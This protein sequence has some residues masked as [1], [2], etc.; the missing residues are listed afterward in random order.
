MTLIAASGKATRYAL[1]D[2]ANNLIAAD[3]LPGDNCLATQLTVVSNTDENA[4]VQSL[5]SKVAAFPPLPATG[6]LEAGSIYSYG[7]QALVVR[8]S[9]FRTT[10]APADT[11]NLFIVYRA[12]AAKVLDWIAGEK[13][14]V[15]VH[16]LYGGQEYKCLQ[17]HVTQADWTPDR[18]P[19]LWAL[20]VEA[21]SGNEWAVGVTYKA[22]DIVTYKGVTY[23]CTIGHTSISVW[24][25]DVAVSLWTKV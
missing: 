2:A 19:N 20:Y 1:F 22:D 13:V 12:D 4:F 24:T 17:A 5:S 11:P 7:G 23:K 15:G 25:P 8:I 6:W 3:T 10:F 9:H 14:E 18:T 16:R 21:P